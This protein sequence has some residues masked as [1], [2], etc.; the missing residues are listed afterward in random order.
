MAGVGEG[1]RMAE[2]EK[3]VLIV[4]DDDDAREALA[5]FL[6]AEGYS[7]LEAAHGE[8]ALRQLRSA[9]V[10]AILLDLMMPVM[11]GWTFRAEQLKDAALAAIPVA[12]LTAD[13]TAAPKVAALHVE[14]CMTKPV[15]F[16]RLL[17]FVRRHC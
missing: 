16:D 10:S 8:E 4:E 5:V 2:S 11:N 6:Q 17:A 7:V 1:R 12:V 9:P 14:D 15:D 13:A 3:F